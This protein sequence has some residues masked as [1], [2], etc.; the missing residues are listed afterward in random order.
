MKLKI[1]VDLGQDAYFCQFYC[2]FSIIISYVQCIYLRFYAKIF[3]VYF[4]LSFWQ[5]FPYRRPRIAANGRT[6]CELWGKEASR[7][8][9][10]SI[11]ASNWGNKP[12]LICDSN[13]T[14]PEELRVR[15][16]T[17]SAHFM[18]ALVK[19]C[20]PNYVYSRGDQPYELRNPHF[21]RQLRQKTCLNSSTQTY[22]SNT[23]HSLRERFLLA[24]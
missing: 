14:A 11:P 5:S 12:V 9:S 15:T 20:C 19:I 10:D 18:D 24:T 22:G 6:I 7:C 4:I 16:I 2:E 21:R 17:A 1:R 23:I 13:R 3:S 8:I